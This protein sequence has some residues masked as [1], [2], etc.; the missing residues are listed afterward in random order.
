MSS[1]S[2]HHWSTSTH[3]Y[4]YQVEE[5]RQLTSTLALSVVPQKKTFLGRWKSTFKK[6]AMEAL[7][8][9]DPLLSSFLTTTS[10]TAKDPLAIPPILHDPL[11]PLTQQTWQGTSYDLAWASAAQVE[12][13][14][15]T[16]L[17]TSVLGI[18]QP[19]LRSGSTSFGTT[20]TFQPPPSSQGGV[21]LTDLERPSQST[22]PPPKGVS[23]YRSLSSLPLPCSE[24]RISP[25][26]EQRALLKQDSPLP[27]HQEGITGGE[28]PI[29]PRQTSGMIQSPAQPGASETSLP[30]RP[31]E[32]WSLRGEPLPPPSAFQEADLPGTSSTEIHGEVILPPLLCQPTPLSLGRAL[33]LLSTGKLTAVPEI[34]FRASIIDLFNHFAHELIEDPDWAVTLAGI[35]Y[36]HYGY[37]YILKGEARHFACIAWNMIHPQ[38]T[39]GGLAAA[40]KAH[41]VYPVVPDTELHVPPR[42]RTA[43]CPPELQQLPPAGLPPPPPPGPLQGPRWWALPPPPPDPPAPWNL[44][45]DNQGPWAALKPNMVK[46]PENFNGDSNDIARFFS[47]C[48]M[49]FSVFNQYFRYHPHKVIFAASHFG[50]DAQVWWE[51]CTRELG[52]DVYGEQLY[53][54]YDQFVI[55]VRQRFWKD[56]NT[57]I[58]LAQWEALRQKTFTDGNLFFQQFKSLAFEAGVFSI[59]QMMVAQ[60][61]KACRSTT[62]DIIYGTDGDLPTSYQEWK[63]RILW[64]N[65]NW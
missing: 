53:P 25:S 33:Y 57:K 61:K 45:P 14:F 16:N 2:S 20:S 48:D 4:P 12:C 17:P 26:S 42:I 19:A 9:Q 65:Y 27:G 54:D 32:T 10:R 51:L 5:P 8:E 52:R 22:S 64:I 6:E 18:H 23:P 34:L 39:Y 50:K 38:Q 60:V 63:K 47:Q 1:H 55:E 13:Q 31:S 43:R 35:G 44:V 41:H 58:K 62:K 40:S 56:T 46:E 28:S 21:T 37:S 24:S 11:L 15:Q 36:T 49:Y 7:P 29:S 59:D 30:K 3:P